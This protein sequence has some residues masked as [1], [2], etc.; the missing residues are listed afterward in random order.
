MRPRRCR[1]TEP[2]DLGLL[3]DAPG[4]RRVT[5]GLNLRT[6]ALKAAVGQP[7]RVEV[8]LRIGDPPA[9]APAAPEGR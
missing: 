6:D 5:V 7:S 8:E 4:T 2:I 1:C 3:P 9:P